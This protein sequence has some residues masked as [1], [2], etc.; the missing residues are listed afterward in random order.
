M[1]YHDGYTALDGRSVR[2]RMAPRKSASKNTHFPRTAEICYNAIIPSQE[3]PTGQ[4]GQKARLLVVA[5][6]EGTK[7]LKTDV[8][9]ETSG[10]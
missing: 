2:M 4:D 6:Q 8:L 3:M 7:G 10:M 9:L 5:S 1:T